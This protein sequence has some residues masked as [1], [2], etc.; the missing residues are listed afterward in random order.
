MEVAGVC[1]SSAMFINNMLIDP[2]AGMTDEELI[3]N[4]LVRRYI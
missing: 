2:Y 1:H 3:P 4:P